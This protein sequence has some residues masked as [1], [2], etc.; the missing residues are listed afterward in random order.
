MNRFKA[1]VFDLD[2]TLLDTLDDLADSMNYVLEANGFPIHDINEYKY[3]VGNGLRNLVTKALPIEHRNNEAIDSAFNNMLEEYRKRWYNKTTPYDGIPELLDQLAAREIKLAIL[4]NKEHGITLK[5]VEKFLSKWKFEV[6]FGERMGVPR[7]P[8]PTSALEIIK[9]LG[10]PADNIIYLG[11]SG[12]DMQ[13]ANN[14][15]MYAVGASW[16]FRGTEE[17]LEAGAQ[18]II[19]TPMELMG[20]IPLP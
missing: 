9:I 5:I 3:F 12:S 7:K 16:G 17:L 2:G 11:D 8:D 4:S 13:T 14:S 19:D 6:V 10:T 18:C 15:G 1:V 20:M